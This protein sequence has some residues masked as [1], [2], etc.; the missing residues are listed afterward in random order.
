MSGNKATRQCQ[1]WFKGPC[2]QDAIWAG[3]KR[4][5]LSSP[6]GRWASDDATI[7][8]RS[9]QPPTAR[10]CA[11]T[12]WWCLRRSPR[13]P[14]WNLLCVVRHRW[15][16][17]FL[18]AAATLNSLKW[19]ANVVIMKGNRRH[20]CNFKDKKEILRAVMASNTQYHSEVACGQECV[21]LL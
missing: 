20:T 13:R 8:A 19:K 14:H 18:H 1:A 6:S 2:W 10:Y 4:T 7:T 11:A 12:H 15:P 16:F 5:S 17:S 21:L 3:D 9:F